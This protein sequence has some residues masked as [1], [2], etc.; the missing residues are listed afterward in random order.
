MPFTVSYHG[1]GRDAGAVPPGPPSTDRSTAHHAR[2][3]DAGCRP[4]G[5]SQTGHSHR[6]QGRRQTLTL[7]HGAL[8]RSGCVGAKCCGN[9]RLRHR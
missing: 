8:L 3:C 1:N 6:G 2:A 9:A 4:T 7:G 5:R